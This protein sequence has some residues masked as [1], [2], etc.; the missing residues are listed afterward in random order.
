[1]G[2]DVLLEILGT[3][4]CLLAKVAL[5]RLER[6]VDADMGRDV[7]SLDRGRAAGAPGASQ[8]QIVGRL[9]TDMAF[10]DVVLESD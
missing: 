9:A 5:V 6:D 10:A 2:L 7:V 8:V 4:K 3:F 1:M